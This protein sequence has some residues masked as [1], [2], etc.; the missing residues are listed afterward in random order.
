M[1][2]SNWIAYYL[3]NDRDLLGNFVKEIL[4]I[5]TFNPQ[6]AKII[7]EYHN[8]DLWIEDP[9]NIIVIENKIK[10]GIN[11]VNKERHDLKD[12]NIQSQLSKYV[13]YV[14]K[15]K[16]EGQTAYYFIFLPNYSYSGENLSAYTNGNQ[17]TIK[18]Y[19]ELSDFFEKTDCDLDYYEDFRRAIKKHSFEREKDMLEITNEKMIQTIRRKKEQ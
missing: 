4:K 6:Q 1:A 2:C 5:K 8:I 18:R 10:S 12:K 15:N 11:G 14:D 9:E 16:E 13:N 17:Y 3:D 7:R 19:K